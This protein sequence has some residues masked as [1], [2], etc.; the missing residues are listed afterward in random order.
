MLFRS[1]ESKCA[2]DDYPPTHRPAGSEQHQK[3]SGSS[4]GATSETGPGPR[5]SAKEAAIKSGSND[6]DNKYPPESEENTKE[7]EKSMKR[8]F[9]NGKRVPE[10]LDNICEPDQNTRKRGE[11]HYSAKFSNPVVSADFE[12]V[13][14]LFRTT[15]VLA[16]STHEVFDRGKSF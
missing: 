6:D 10:I 5:E 15:E 16:R 2:V 11:R 8:K 14:H 12:T 3:G 4:V 9:K 7:D 1:G 13:D